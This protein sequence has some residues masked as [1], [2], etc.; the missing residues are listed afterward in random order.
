MFS[1][2]S[3]CSIHYL[4]VTFTTYFFLYW[5]CQIIDYQVWC[6][7]RSHF[8]FFFYSIIWTSSSCFK[9]P[10]LMFTKSTQFPNTDSMW[11]HCW[12]SVA[13]EDLTMNQHWV[14]VSCWLGG[15]VRLSWWVVVVSHVLCRG[16][17]HGQRRARGHSNVFVLIWPFS[18]RRWANL[19]NSNGRTFWSW[20]TMVCDVMFVASG[21]SKPPSVRSRP[22]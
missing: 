14:S 11:V 12:A 13:D 6:I 20:W 2:V 9:I 3:H 18:R 1:Q 5:S 15:G 7:F 4:F 8:Q 19:Y 16:W 17:W 10:F 22:L 21:W